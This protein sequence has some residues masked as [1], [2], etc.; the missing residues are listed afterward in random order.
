MN[1]ADTLT[2]WHAPFSIRSALIGAYPRYQRAIADWNIRTLE[3]V[4]MG[5]GEK[6][7]HE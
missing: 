3:N 7:T 5:E 1:V 2:A 6:D 4:G